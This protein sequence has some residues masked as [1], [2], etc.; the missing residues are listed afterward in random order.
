VLIDSV[1]GTPPAE[2][3]APPNLT[4]RMLDVI[5]GAKAAAERACLGVVSCA[6]VVALA[7]RDAYEVPTGRR[8]GVVS[9]AIEAR[10]PSPSA[11]FAEA[12]DVSEHR[13][14]LTRSHRL[15]RYCK[16]TTII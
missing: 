10:L 13:A 15:V 12:L 3:D 11:S 2:K 7:A 9:S 4:L 8:D 16:S 5:D 6:D 1:P 14:Q